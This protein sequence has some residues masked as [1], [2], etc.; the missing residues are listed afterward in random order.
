MLVLASQSQ[1]RRAMLDAARRANEEALASEGRMSC[2]MAMRKL[3]PFHVGALMY[4][5]FLAIAYEGALEEV[6]AYDQPGVEDYKKI[7][8]EDLRKYIVEHK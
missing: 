5:F 6:N 1:S 8:H 2:H 4:F 7:L 3:T